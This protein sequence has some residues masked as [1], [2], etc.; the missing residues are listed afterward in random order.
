KESEVLAA[1]EAAESLRRLARL[2][3]QLLY[4]DAMG[5]AQEEAA[6]GG[7]VIVAAFYGD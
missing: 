2:D 7:L 1:A 5:R 3:A 6:R 4:R